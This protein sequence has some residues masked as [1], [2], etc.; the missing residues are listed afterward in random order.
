MWRYVGRRLLLLVPVLIGVTLL[1]FTLTRMGGD[2]SAI[3]VNSHMP[4]EAREM[5]RHN[6]HLDEDPVTQY[7][8]WL[9]GMLQGQWGYSSTNGDVPV[10]ECITTFLPAT[11]EL[12]F[13]AMAIALVVGLYLGKLSAVRR[14][15]PVD[16]ATR[17]FAL[18]G[19]ALPVFVAALLLQFIFYSQLHWLPAVGRYDAVLFIQYSDTW[20]TYTGFFLVDSLLNGNVT[21][22]ADGLAHIILP[23]LALSFGAIAIIARMMRSS[24]LEVM[25]LDYIKTAR[26]KG[27]PERTVIDKHV[28]KNALI[29]TTTVAGLMF[30]GLLGGA[31]ITET[32][33]SWP[34]MG[35]WSKNAFVAFDTA[36]IMGFVLVT[37]FFYVISNL[38]VDII[39]AYLDPRVR[40]G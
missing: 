27:L 37:A 13:V 38:V 33:F 34:G 26:S 2:P 30:G 9:Q 14:N 12:T 18:L 31:I 25:G 28:R 7:F 15:R 10:T 29:P 24:M 23:A 17:V 36:A 21:M 20:Q 19:V 5:V 8:Y 22:F 35:L 32:I 16:H 40:L 11:F 4:P 6:M 3:Y 1:V 39:Y